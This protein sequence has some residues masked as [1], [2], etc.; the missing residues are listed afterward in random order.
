MINKKLGH[1]SVKRIR[2]TTVRHQAVLTKNCKDLNTDFVVYKIC[3]VFK[4][5]IPI[6]VRD[7]C[8]NG[9]IPLIE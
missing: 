5:F 1:R 4:I 3:F 6:F 2:S 7:R 8:K 9:S